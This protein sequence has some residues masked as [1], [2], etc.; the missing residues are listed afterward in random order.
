MISSS[1]IFW[2]IVWKEPETTLLRLGKYSG[3]E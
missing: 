2:E 1:V 3:K